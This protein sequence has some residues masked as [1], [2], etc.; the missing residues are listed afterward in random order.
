M[1]EFEETEEGGVSTTTNENLLHFRHDGESVMVL[2]LSNGKKHTF[3]TRGEVETAVNDREADQALWVRAMTMVE[4]G[5]V[6][7]EHVVIGFTIAEY[8]RGYE[9]KDD[10]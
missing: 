2:D 8:L 10:K 1:I 6:D 4:Q 3:A 5:R 9:T 7:V